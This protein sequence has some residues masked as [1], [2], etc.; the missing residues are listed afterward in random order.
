MKN[1]VVGRLLY[2]SIVVVLPENSILGLS[3][4][5]FTLGEETHH[6]PFICMI[7]RTTVAPMPPTSNRA[8]PH[9][10]HQ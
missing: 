2:K 1:A 7:A 3:S 6:H 9:K 8:S 5:D 10:M 4:F